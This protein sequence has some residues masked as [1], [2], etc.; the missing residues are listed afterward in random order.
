MAVSCAINGIAWLSKAWAR[1]IVVRGVEE[2]A[3]CDASGGLLRVS[4]F[5]L[6]VGRDPG[7]LGSRRFPPVQD[8]PCSLLPGA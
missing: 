6:G 1:T 7:S 2:D 4:P 8:A 3:F 5:S